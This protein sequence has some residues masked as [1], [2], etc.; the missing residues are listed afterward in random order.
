[1]KREMQRD[2]YVKKSTEKR[3]KRKR[4]RLKTFFVFFV[5]LCLCIGIVLSLTVFFPIEN[6]YCEGS[7]IYQPD[8]IIK[9]TGIEKGDNLF[10]VS[11][12]EAE[13][14]LKAKLPYIE[15][16]NFK[17]ELPGTLKITAKD[18]EEFA[19]YKVGDKYYTVSSKG[20]VMEESTEP[21][22]KIFTV[23]AKGVKCK[24]GSE[25]KFA[26]L[27]Q[28]GMVDS[29]TDAL[30]AENITPNEIDVTDNLA[31]TVKVEGRFEVNL[32]NANNITEKIRHLSGMI[33]NM[34]KGKG[35]KINLSMWTSNNPKGTFVEKKE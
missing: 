17:R 32:G 5:F 22:E 31:L 21:K 3:R 16:V 29:I 23:R 11:R 20:W 2:D 15:T 30:K 8:Q 13:K 34:P 14:R 19:S 12:S 6:I 10:V 28:K 27:S 26:D 24:V 18:A 35:G 4:R 9:M 7:N 25:I 33:K 1:L